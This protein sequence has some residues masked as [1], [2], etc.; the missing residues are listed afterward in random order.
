[1]SGGLLPLPDG[2]E[3][4]SRTGGEPGAPLTAN[5]RL[6]RERRQPFVAADVVD[7]QPNVG[8]AVFV[9][10]ATGPVTRTGA[11]TPLLGGLIPGMPPAEA[12]GR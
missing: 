11:S 6:S 4:H 10:G 2:Q 8:D 7:G 9:G 3:M 5:L 1:M 12:D